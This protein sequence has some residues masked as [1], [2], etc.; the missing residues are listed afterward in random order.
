M[1]QLGV[2]SALWSAYTSAE[3]TGLLRSSPD[4]ML[5]PFDLT[6]AERAALAAQDWRTLLEGGAHPFLMFKLLLRLMGPG[7]SMEYLQSY[8]G[9][10]EG[11]HLRDIV[12]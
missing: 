1:S 5:A 8:L 4:A 7:F 12:T 3:N 6:E 10:L 2:N 9:Q 11:A